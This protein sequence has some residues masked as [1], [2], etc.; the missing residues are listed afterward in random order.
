MCGCVGGVGGLWWEGV[1]GGVVCVLGVV[2]GGV[3]CGFGGEGWGCMV[4]VLVVGVGV[5]G[6]VCV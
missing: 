2:G 4:G 1:V 6:W 5:C 3:V